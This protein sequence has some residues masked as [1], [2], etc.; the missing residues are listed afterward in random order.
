MNPVS[1]RKI[2]VLLLLVI[3]TSSFGQKTKAPWLKYQADKSIDSVLNTMTVKEM[4]AQ[5]I[6][7]PAWDYNGRINYQ[8]V[9]KL[10]TGYG[11]GGILFNE[12]KAEKQADLVRRLD[13][14][15]K[16]PLLI[17]TDAEWGTGMRLE[18]VMSYPYQ[19]TLGAIQNDSLIYRMGSYIAAE[20]RAVGID[21]NLAP[22]ADVNN[23]P[24]NPVINFRSFGES[25]VAVARKAAMFM[26]GMQDNGVIACAK[27]FPGHGDTDVDSHRGLP[28]IEA[29]RERF[30][31]V[32]F[33]PFRYLIDQGIAS[34]MTAHI[35]VPTLDSTPKLPATYSYKIVTGV[36]KNEMNFSGLVITDALSM[37]GAK[38]AFPAGIADANAY[39]AGNDILEFS[40]NPVMA[41]EEISSRVT[42]GEIP[43]ETVREKCRK[44][45]AVKR[46]IAEEAGKNETHGITI[47]NLSPSGKMALIRDLYANA[48]TVVENTSSLIPLKNL[49]KIRVATVSVNGENMGTF[50]DMASRYTRVDQFEINT[51]DTTGFSKTLEILKEYDVILTGVSGLSQKPQLSYGITEEM[52]SVISQ[53]ASLNGCIISWFGNPFGINLLELNNKPSALL[54]AYQDNSFTQD[55]A[56]E[57]IF[58]AIGASGRLPVSINSKYPAGTGLDT[59]GNLRLQYGYPENASMSSELLNSKVDSIVKMGLDSLAY[60]GCE[61]LIA[62]KGI[63]V[64]YKT[65]G[66]HTYEK[67]DTVKTSDLFDLASV[68]KISSTTAALLLLDSQG[69]FDPDRTL[70][71]YLPLFKGTNKD[72]LRLRD[73]LSHQSGLIPFIPFYKTTLNP[74]GSFK[75]C[76]YS[77]RKTKRYNVEVTESLYI[78]RNYRAKMYAEIVDSKVGPRKYLYSDLNFILAADVAKSITGE[79]ID[80]YLPVNIYNRLGAWDITFRPREKYALDRI[81]PTE[82]DTFFRHQ[83]LHGT[84]HDEGAAMF[85]GVSGHAGLFATGNDLLKLIETY[86]RMGSYGGEQ[87]FSQDIMKEYTSVQFPE[88]DNRR[89]L[90]FDKPTLLN[91]TIPLADRYPSPSVSDASFGHSGYTGTFVWADPDAEISYVFLCNRVYPTRNNSKL[92]DM[93]IRPAI[94]EASI[95]AIMEDKRQKDKDK[96]K[97]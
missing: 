32:E 10:V 70:G 48:I 89:G 21:V 42:K 27:H 50:R 34:V 93:N 60:P 23:N 91:D 83:Q 71:S 33:M 49:D 12:G 88:N 77:S 19:M 8:E 65:F 40:V 1:G 2:A 51:A 31:T 16:I 37:E 61:V 62:R 41:I 81:V 36:L 52:K 30:D 35:N 47:D 6:W 7:I 84:V 58:G 64:Y 44:I 86:R 14:L 26:K 72:S 56:V 94:L 11:I 59:P 53:L 20:C 75:K 29:S 17:A 4:V 80:T 46:W 25:P 9:E 3:T 39:I 22:V 54:I 90:C 68:T 69:K 95:N 38:E 87:I 63:V 74:D 85:G 55:V 97:E 76:I 79:S 24:N 73:M 43:I 67:K 66:Y 45:L 13:S 28:L 82:N 57:V 18:G 5:S 96:S 92:Y 78:N 15:S